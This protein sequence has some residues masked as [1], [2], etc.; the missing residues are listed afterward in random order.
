MGSGAFQKALIWQSDDAYS[1]AGDSASLPALVTQLQTHAK[2]L[3]LPQLKTDILAMMSR[4]TKPSLL[5]QI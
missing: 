5:R 3:S 2:S 4:L 1:M